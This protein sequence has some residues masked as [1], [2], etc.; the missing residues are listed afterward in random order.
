MAVNEEGRFDDFLAISG[1]IPDLASLQPIHSGLRHKLYRCGRIGAAV[2]LKLDAAE[3]TGAS[4]AAS[5][6]HQFE[7]LR[8]IKLPGIVRVLGLVDTGRGL[9]LAMEDAGDRNL[10]QLTQSGP[11]S[12]TAFLNVAIQLAE[13]VARLHDAR[14]IHRDIHPGNV[15]WNSESEVA[16]L[17]DFAIARTLPTL[18]MESPNP[19][20]L[21]GTLPYMSPEQTGR[22]GRS[23]DWRADLYSLGATFYETLTGAPPFAGGDATA[24]AHAQIARLARPVHEIN[25]HVPLALSRIV[26]KLL[27]KEPEHRYQSA[28]ALAEDLRDA[29]T[30]WLRSAT[31]EPFPLASHEVPRGLTVPDRLY[32]RD[33]EL[34]SLTDAFARTR[35]GGRELVLVT[36]GPGIGKSALVD[37][38]RPAVSD[39]HGYY[40]AGKFDQLQR[41]V[42]FSGLAQALRSL[43]RQLLTESEA[44]LDGWRERIDHAVAPNGRLLVAI[45]PELERLIGPQPPILEAGPVESINRFRLVV[46]RFLRVFAR[47]EHPLVLFLDDLQWI[48]AASLQLLEQWVSDAASHHLLVIGAYRDNEVGPSHPLALSLSGLRDAGCDIH[49]IH[50]KP[51]GSDAI[52]QL[53]ADTFGEPA[54][55]MRF[56]ADLIIRKSAGNPFFVRRLLHLMYAQGLFRFLSDTHRWTWDESEIERAPISDNVL[57]LMV[58]A[59]D[60]LPLTAKQL[61]ET[62]ACIGHQFELGTLAELTD[63]S[64]EAATEE[65]WPAIEDGL[66]VRVHEASERGH[67]ERFGSTTPRGP[68][69]RFAHDRVQQAAYDRLSEPSRQAL[70][71]AIGRR[72]LDRAGDALDDRL[73]EIVDQLD[74]GQAHVVGDAE[75]RSLV[76]LN[77]A[78]GQKA[79]A[80]AAYRA[81]FEY[82]TV[83]RR[84][85]GARAWDEHPELTFAVHRELAESAYLAGEHAT[86]EELVE[87]TLEH[88]QSKTAQADLYGLRVLAATVAS[89]WPR[90]LHWGRVGLSVFGLEWPL[91]GLA[92]AIEAEAAAIMKNLGARRI[93]DLIDEPDVEDEDIRASMRLL[94]LLGAPAYFSGAEVITFLFARAVNISLMHGPS[95]YSAFAFVLYGGIHNALTGQYEVGYAFGKLA[96]ALARRF[97]N[98]A[99]ECRTL[100]VYGVLVHH[101]KAPL[102]EGLPLLK[103]GFR[104]GA[105]SGET[106]FAAFSLNAFLINALP[107][108]MPLTDLLEEAAVAVDFAITQKNKTSVEM[109]LVHRQIARALIGATS[110]PDC[111]DD[112][113]FVE[114]HFLEQAGGH[115]TAL[116]HF[117]VAKL[118]TACL[119]GDYGKA[120]ECSREAER[121]ILKGILGM[122]TSA[123][124]VFYTALAK[125]AAA[126]VSPSELPSSLDQLRTLHGKLV[127]W[128]GHCPQNFAHKVSLVG[129]EIARLERRLGDASILYR[130]AIDE[131]ERQ[132]FIQDE[133]LAHELRARCLL[134]EHEPAFA[135]VHLR[136][137][138]DRYRQWGATAKV[139]ALEHEFPECF[140][141]EPL[142]PSRPISLDEMALVKASQAISIETT[143]ERLFEQILRVVVE[144][145][146]AQRGAL[147]LPVKGA[148]KVRARIEAAEEFSVSLSEMPLE[149]CIDLPS[150]I[151]RYVMRTKEFL[152]LSDAGTASLF[153]N[154]PVV[155]QRKLQSVLCIPLIKQATLLG[156][157]YLEN[158]GMAGAFS[159]EL[160]EIGRVLAAQAVISLENSTLLEEL[161]QLTGALEARVA[162]RTQQLTDQIVA[163]DRAEAALRQSEERQ[164]FMLRLTDTLR[165]LADSAEIQGHAC[166]L[167][168]EQLD[169]N[170]AYFVQIDETAGIARVERDALRGGA[171]SL[172]GEHRVADYAWS[173][174]ILRRGERQVIADTQCSD[175]VP[176]ADRPAMAALQIAATLG[177]PLVKEGRLVGALC[178]TDS[179]TREWSDSEVDLVSEV[180]ERIW[181]AVERARVEAVVRASEERLREADRR[182]DEFIAMLAHEL[183]NPL[184][185]IRTGLELIRVAG[186]TPAA[187]ERVRSTMDRQV[188]HMVRLIDDLLDVSRISSGKIQLHQEPTP[189]SS[190]VNSAIEANRAAITAKKIELG[191]DLPQS[192][193][194]LDVDPTRFVQVL[195]N[196]LHNAT[197]FT[198]PGG[199]IHV[200]GRVSES[201]GDAPPQL[202][203]SVSDS[204]I[205]IPREFL[206][207]VFDLFSQ[208]NG[209]SSQGGLGIG[210]ALARR[211]VEM[212]GGEIEVRSEGPGHGSEFVIRLPL[213]TQS[214][215]A[216]GAETSVPHRIDCRVMVI[217]DNR[218]AA[219]VMAMLVEELGGHCRTAYDGESGVGE[220]L[221]YRPHVVLLDIGMP[222]L[223][224]F[225]TCR[226]IRRE[227]GNDVMVVALTGFGQ[228][229]DKE[230]T[231]QYGFDAHLTKPADPAALEKLLRQCGS[232]ERTP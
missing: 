34:Q 96:L 146:G 180:G 56:L 154:D 188:S 21:E 50:L 172:A 156:L 43:V 75:R 62:G 117:W 192:L 131:A 187:V 36:G 7:L 77:L 159:D 19:K 82:L 205:G 76:E 88:A 138:R 216:R 165:P 145:T 193:C 9:A 162:E 127:N 40:A 31:I 8:H 120:L 151:L 16:T 174:A 149:Q 126:T 124:H 155:Q 170:R 70:H 37:H 25:P 1:P 87:I 140:R 186:N 161:Q 3:L 202:A 83:A 11:L 182:K 57:D 100:E 51:L 20:Q 103:E 89:D 81:A 71:H 134:G 133:A 122:I 52:A 132:R 200:S 183:R 226:R 28:T 191:V 152:L 95:P 15:V 65:L 61:L 129:A 64:M 181:A 93:E 27:E 59:I 22:T 123:E 38:I 108:G 54:A 232:N 98:R 219:N 229:Q 115:E 220:M 74:L 201:H 72:L 111:F 12:I 107:S 213:C 67:L 209:G 23:V 143:P 78:A 92:G 97:G 189:L 207:R 228:Q 184:A 63:R 142:A 171:P 214:P 24:L 33:E 121:R 135:A 46:T 10:A 44:S 80:S 66:V 79:K 218:D 196:L 114:A 60:R 113:E 215:P 173:V 104:A 106:A 160:V 69:L 175:L 91:E 39:G 2:V 148:L 130:T 48:D 110:R 41:S 147:V 14:I 99:E 157:I 227:L 178:V 212:Q 53:A 164:A 86:A 210:L 197:K 163:R 30:Q 204:G 58:L 139:S 125:A 35:N 49:T 225:E 199:A 101:W 118:Q 144:V 105:E 90:A 32:G 206:P 112:D 231:R 137:A 85:L 150:A 18:V 194:V 42:P 153:G 179:R 177:V 198:E 167:L 158:N 190:L 176:E 166:R 141:S 169:V 13:A 26:L 224:G 116:G 208:G 55:R 102:R 73:F 94:S 185:P 217:D 136:L 203:L 168:A 4:A 47:P 45:V 6:R 68:A 119:M 5:V 29:R 222:G 128:A 84:H 195:S 17:C 230:R 109:A 221:T 211:L 223:D